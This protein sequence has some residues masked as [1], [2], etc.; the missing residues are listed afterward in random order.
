MNIS[1]SRM[2]KIFLNH[3]HGD[4]VNDLAHIYWFG[5]AADRKS[6]LYVWGP[7]ASG[8]TCPAWGDNQPK[9]YDDGTRAFCEHI[10]GAM[11]WATESS[12]PDSALLHT[13]PEGWEYPDAGV[14]PDDSH[15]DDGASSPELD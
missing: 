14:S 11:R 1:P 5:P 2:D 13:P 7:S 4:H 9:E 15:M 12:L 6:P 8:I 10:R 3:L